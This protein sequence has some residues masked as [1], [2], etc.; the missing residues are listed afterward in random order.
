MQTSFPG[1][2]G[3]PSILLLSGDLRVSGD[4]GLRL[5]ARQVK[6]RLE[7]LA[8]LR[9]PDLG[10]RLQARQVKILLIWTMTV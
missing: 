9:N 8:R 6:V 7:S 3:R 1:R 4:L 2:P 10:L 5:Q